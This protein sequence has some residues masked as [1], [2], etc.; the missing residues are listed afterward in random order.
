MKE[1]INLYETA[2][3]QRRVEDTQK[4]AL[5]QQE[6]MLQQQKLNNLLSVGSLVMQG[7]ALDEMSRHNA[8]AEFEMQKAN[9]TLP[10]Q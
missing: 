1:A 3:H 4:Q 6:Q 2:L 7:A 5:Q 9:R 8:T 10:N